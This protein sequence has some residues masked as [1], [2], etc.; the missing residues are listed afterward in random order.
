VFIAAV[1]VGL[2]LF[3]RHRFRR[4]FL[5]L[6]THLIHRR[7]S[8]ASGQAP[9]WHAE[10][11]WTARGRILRLLHRVSPGAANVL[12]EHR[13]LQQVGCPSCGATRDMPNKKR[14]AE[15]GAPAGRL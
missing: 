5:L 1:L 6:R 3:E 8:R 10:T 14:P 9:W 12:E 15:A 11:K 2:V 7:A 4:Q 13:R